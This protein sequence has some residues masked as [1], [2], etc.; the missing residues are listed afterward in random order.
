[1]KIF[2]GKLES[3]LETDNLKLLQILDDRYA[4]MDPGAFHSRA[5][6]KYW[7]GKKRFFN[8]K[9]G[10]FK[11]GLLPRVLKDLALINAYPEVVYEFEANNEPMDSHLIKGWTLHDYQDFLVS[12]ALLKR[13]GVILSPTGSGK[14]LIMGSIIKA[15]G[16]RRILCLFNQKSL[17]H[18]TYEY[19]TSKA[20][21]G[22]NLTKE[23]GI[24]VGVNFSDGYQ[25]GDV[26]LCSVFSLEKILGTPME[27]PDVLLVD[28]CHEFSKG[29]LSSD[30]ISI[31]ENAEY[32]LGFTG[33]FPSDKIKAF[34]L[35]GSLGPVI[36]HDKASTSALILDDKIAKP[37]IQVLPIDYFTSE[38]TETMDY[39]SVYDQYI[40]NNSFRNA[41]IGD[42]VT[43]IQAKNSKSKVIILVQNLKHGVELQKLIPNSVYLQGK[44][45]TTERAKEITK[46]RKS[47][48][49]EVLIGTKILQTGVN[50]P[51]ITHYINARGLSSD[52]ATIQ[53]LGRSLR[54]TD[55]VKEVYVYDIIDDVKY[56]RDHGRDRVKAY[57]SQ[58]HKVEYLPE[59]H[60]NEIT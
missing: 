36:S 10:K 20:P 22:L 52:I 50:I 39:P 4:F 13:R 12:E 5:Y 30:A 27:D 34:T 3:K 59:I 49:N 37:I 57:K 26:M 23:Y 53:A 40:I 2:V 8:S 24:S 54:V 7:D 56:L 45:E 41:I 38:E 15:L 58:G 18:Q 28:E 1:M 25:Y 48:G 16:N 9:T 32:R 60:C 17:I 11:S 14:T 51:E 21:K 6:P 29:K 42:I 44:D 43:K 19:L 31:F 47:K 46:F 35:E 55:E 33:T